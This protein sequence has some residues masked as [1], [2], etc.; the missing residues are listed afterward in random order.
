MGTLYLQDGTLFYGRSFGAA[1]TQVGEIVFNTCMTGY[2]E[3]V[4]DPSYTGQ[5]VN[6]TYPLIGNYG[7]NDQASESKKPHLL[8]LVV[9]KLADIASNYTCEKTLDSFLTGHNVIAITDIDTR[10][11]TR[12]I[13]ERASLIAVISSE[14]LSLEDC[15][16]LTASY[17]HP[18]NFVQQASTKEIVHIPGPGEKIAVLDFGIK[19]SILNQLLDRGCDV[20]LFPYDSGFDE[21][22]AANPDGILLSNGPGDPM[23]IAPVMETVRRLA[24][25]RP[26]AGICLGHQL[27]CLAFGG[28][29]YKLGYGHHG[30]NHGVY[31]LERDRCFIASQNH[32]YAV[33]EDSLENT[34]LVVTHINLNDKTVEGMRHRFLPIVSVQFHPEASPGPQD[35][36]YI[37]ESFLSAVREKQWQEAPKHA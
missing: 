11:V 33:L 23:D 13:R 20:T 9:K 10:K 12:K 28:K 35:S 30:G 8:G 14:A 18:R 15:Q 36:S 22:M 2:Q 21:I 29:T 25:V 31:D 4:T 16:K 19:R 7:I 27:L 1:G 6:M 26:I 24:R 5:I 17:R 34:E 32:E 3:V 37:F